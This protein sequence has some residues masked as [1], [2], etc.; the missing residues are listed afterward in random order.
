M[1][2]ETIKCPECDHIQAAKVEETEI[3]NVYIHDCTNCEYTI[4]ESE[5]E[6]VED[7]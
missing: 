6:K 7:K 2:I 3:W 1:H 4:M 5:W